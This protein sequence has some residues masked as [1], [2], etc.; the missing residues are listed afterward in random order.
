M[1]GNE[2]D[3]F[4]EDKFFRAKDYNFEQYIA[5]HSEWVKAVRT[6]VPHAPFAGPDTEGQVSTWVK[7][8]AQHTRSEAVLLTSHFYGM[9]PASDPR[10]TAERLLR[11]VN[12]ELEEQIAQV[13]EARTL[14]GGTP[15]R[16][17]EGNSCFGGGRPGVSDAYTSALWAADYILR[18]ASAGFAGVNLHGGGVGVYTPV[19]SSD[20]AAAAPRPV[21]YGM[22]LAQQFAGFAVS[23]CELKTDANVTAYVG[24]RGEREIR[25]AVVN[26]GA[27]AVQVKLPRAIQ[28]TSMLSGPA[29]DAKTGIKFEET[30]SAGTAKTQTVAGYSAMLWQ[31]G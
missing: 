20:K 13:H 2:P 22:Q 31:H 11:K 19:E 23:P 21:Y 10:M 1:V 9:G 18:A 15:Y 24:T 5:E 14:A 6:K 4:A 25:L 3:G 30:H 29:L 28:R 7:G 26:K 8:Y 27:D 12:P 16:M 17:D